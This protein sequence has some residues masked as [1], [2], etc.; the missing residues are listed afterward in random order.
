V[1]PVVLPPSV[2]GWAF[3]ALTMISRRR[4]ARRTTPLPP[5]GRPDHLTAVIRLPPTLIPR[6]ELRG[7]HYVYPNDTVHVTVSNLDRATVEPEIAIARLRTRDLAAPSF[8]VTGLGCSPDTLFLRCV[9]DTTFAELRRQVRD[10]F[11]VERARPSVSVL[12]RLAFA[13]IVRFDG[14]GEWPQHVKT[15]GEVTGTR[16]EIVRTDRYLSHSATSVVAELPLAAA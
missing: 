4:S 15:F 14:P 6:L 11:G 7:S 5:L 3:D 9:H 8:V 13:N 2:Q 10:A 12:S 1:R 16:I